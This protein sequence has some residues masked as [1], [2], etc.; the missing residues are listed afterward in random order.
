MGNTS[1]YVKYPT[2]NVFA[3]YVKTL[4]F[5]INDLIT[6]DSKSF[7]DSEYNF[8]DMTVC[9]KYHLVFEREI[10]DLLKLRTNTSKDSIIVLPKEYDSIT[11]DKKRSVCEVMVNHYI[12]I[13]YVLSLIKFA[14]DLGNNGD[15]SVAGIAHRNIRIIDDKIMEIN[16]CKSPH[17][18]FSNDEDSFRVDF[19]KLQGLEFMYTYFF[20]V[21]E[22][23]RFS[24]LL[25]LV[26]GKLGRPSTKEISKIICEYKGN[27]LLVALLQDIFFK[28]RN[29]KN[30]TTCVEKSG[31]GS[32]S[33]S[34]MFH[35][36]KNNMVF[37]N[38]L[39][40][41]IGQIVRRLDTKVGR[42]LLVQYKRITSDYATTVNEMIGILREIVNRDETHSRFVLRD[43][44]KETLEYVIDKTKSHLMAFYVRSIVN[45]QEL[46]QTAMGSTD[47]DI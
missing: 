39:C 40:H 6:D 4:T 26:L 19:S 33:P 31:G 41:D 15:F 2:S 24:K 25:Q 20:T 46:L 43:V 10:K 1:S 8:L 38:D 45:F 7:R 3:P 12:K 9:Q 14:L 27:Q 16:F 47:S 36:E 13:L 44:S 28:R 22:R 32:V 11:L 5:V 17:R 21:A 42:Q 34:L 18:D 35:V 29:I 30:P 23:K 37:S